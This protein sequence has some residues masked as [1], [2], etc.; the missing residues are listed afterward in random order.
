MARGSIVWRCNV[1]GTNTT[2]CKHKGGRYAVIYPVQRWDVAQGKIVKSQ[3]WENAPLNE[4]GASTRDLAETLLAERLKSTHEGSY[5]ELQEITFADFADRWLKEYALGA[6]KRTTY[7]G[8][9]CHVRVH[10]KPAFGASALRALRE[11]TIQG[12]LAST[13]AA[14]AKPKSIKNHLVILKEMLKY[15][16]RWG[17]LATNPAA[18]IKA[19]RVERSEMD[20]LRPDEVRHLLTGV[21]DKDGEPFIRP[22]WYVP[23]K[24]AIF[25]GLR[26]GEQFALRIGDL[27]FHSGQ[28]RVR[29]GLVWY[30]KRHAPDELRWAI[31]TPK[32]KNAVRNVDL[33]PDLL[34]D[35]RRYAAGL[36]DQDPERLLFPSATGTPLDPKN[37]VDRYFRTALTR[38]GLRASLRW[39]DMRHTYASL[40]L[41]SGANIK[42]VSLQMGH[43]SVQ[44]TLDRYSHLMQDSHPAQAARL[45][46]LVFGRPLGFPK[47]IPTEVPRGQSTEAVSANILLT[48]P[49]SISRKTAKQDIRRR[50][51]Q[52]S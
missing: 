38:A 51:T 31:T 41:A 52:A 44:I 16:V 50:V 26:Q 18:E 20:F 17:Y 22:G 1:C 12:Y 8:Y 33:P 43:A 6:V 49:A 3:K 37:V 48:E 35:L 36:P 14:G 30:Q 24:L 9:E 45:S 32:T 40:Q 2:R 34:E 19:P 25:S 10:F 21:S 42:Y 4:R 47:T 28:V 27:D 7:Q 5:R 46:D 29:R 39:H 23:I 15:A 11:D 13:L